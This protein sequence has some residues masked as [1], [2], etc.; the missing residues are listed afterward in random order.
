MMFISNINYFIFDSL[1]IMITYAK[2]LFYLG[3][4]LYT[5]TYFQK[6]YPANFLYPSIYYM[7]FKYLYK[8]YYN[9]Y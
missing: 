4:E 5:I 3:E 1:Y 8:V 9:F 2:S 6:E 7:V